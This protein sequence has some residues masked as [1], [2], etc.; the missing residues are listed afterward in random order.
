MRTYAV[1][2]K[3]KAVLVGLGAIGLTCV[4]LD[5]VNIPPLRPSTLVPTPHSDARS[6]PQM[7]R[8]LLK[9]A[10]RCPPSERI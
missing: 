10:V 7:S 2:A 3:S 6:W 9:L 8:V 4:I 1:Y 5:C